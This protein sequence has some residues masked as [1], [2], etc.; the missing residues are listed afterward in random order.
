MAVI[1]AGRT[2]SNIRLAFRRSCRGHGPLALSRVL[3]R[4]G[5]P[6][7]DQRVCSQSTTW[8]SLVCDAEQRAKKSAPT[9]RGAF[10]KL[11]WKLLGLLPLFGSSLLVSLLHLLRHCDLLPSFVAQNSL[12]GTAAKPAIPSLALLLRMRSATVKKNP[13]YLES[14]LAAA[15]IYCGTP[16]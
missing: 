11:C 5:M 4:K 15:A 6:I 8:T 16:P 14:G 9:D 12:G 10:R 3:P 13:E 1:T 2:R 7:R